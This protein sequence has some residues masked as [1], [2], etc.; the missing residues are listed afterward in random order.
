[1]LKRQEAKKRKLKEAGIEYDFES[2][3]YG[4]TVPAAKQSK[5]TKKST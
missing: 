1:M 5:R 3:G 2:V 4:S